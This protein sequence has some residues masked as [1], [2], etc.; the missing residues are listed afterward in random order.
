[1][2]DQATD[3]L[4]FQR[5]GMSIAMGNASEAVQQEATY[6]TA[7]NEDDGFAKAI[8]ELILP[9]AVAAAMPPAG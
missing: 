7:S 9:R 3:V 4:M 8:E 1:M 2:G 6:V 5:S